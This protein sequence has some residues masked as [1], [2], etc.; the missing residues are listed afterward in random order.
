MYSA[1]RDAICYYFVLQNDT[2]NIVY[3]CLETITNGHSV[4]IFCSTKSWCESLAQTVASEFRT[5]GSFLFT[6]P[7]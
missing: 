5:I 3:L 4:L 2:E 1:T 6:L 7:P